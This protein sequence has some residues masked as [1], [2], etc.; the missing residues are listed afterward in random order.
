M[1]RLHFYLKIQVCI[2]FD[3]AMDTRLTMYTGETHLSNCVAHTKGCIL[4]MPGPDEE[5]C[6]QA[7]R[8]HWV[9]Y[10]TATVS[11]ADVYIQVCHQASSQ[12]KM[13]TH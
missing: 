2:L 10:H 7:V 12:V 1:I 5:L 3:T 13:Q 4:R 8:A 6:K 9:E 11:K